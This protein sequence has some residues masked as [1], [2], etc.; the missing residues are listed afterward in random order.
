MTFPGLTLYNQ[1]RKLALLGLMGYF[2]FILSM[3]G[4]HTDGGWQI[5]S[6]TEGGNELTC[7]AGTV[8]K[9]HRGRFHRQT[10]MVRE[11]EAVRDT[12]RNKRA[13]I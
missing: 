9:M 6:G 1:S 8:R 2:I 3:V 13:V 4:I 5:C 11:D 12:E 7:M 10:N